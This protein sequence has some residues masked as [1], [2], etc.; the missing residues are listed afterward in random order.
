MKEPCRQNILW[1]G[2]RHCHDVGG[3]IIPCHG[4]GQDAEFRPGFPWPTPRFNVLDKYLVQDRLTGLVWLGNA[5]YF[6]FPLPWDEAQTRLAD[7]RKQRAFGRTD[8]RMPNRY[9]LRSLVDHGASK[10]AL[11]REHPFRNVFLNWYWTSTEAA[12]AQGYV[13][14]LQ[15]EGGRMFFGNKE[16]ESFLWPVVGTATINLSPEQL[17]AQAR[18]SSARDGM[19]R[20]DACTGLIW[21]ASAAYNALPLSWSGALTLVA[22]LRITSGL[23][24]RLP[25]INELESLVDVRNHSPALE[26][27]HP[28]G[29]VH[30]GYWSSTTSFY[31]PAWAYVLYMHKGAVGVG[32]K[33]N[34]D[35]YMWPVRTAISRQA[36]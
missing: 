1:T 16:E 33:K 24:W 34:Q 8:W 9:E 28:F 7:L 10:P 32:F 4:S 31:D 19:G 14:R 27:E 21:Y 26:T 30:E 11:P 22:Q 3:S 13:W 36:L 2:Q 35:F 20:V 15:P 29:L 25:T 18:F 5:N 23:P 12:M 17:H 6:E